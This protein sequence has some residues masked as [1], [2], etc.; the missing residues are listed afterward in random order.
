[1]FPFRIF[2]AFGKTENGKALDM[3]AK[4]REYLV[5]VW[6]LLASVV[7][8]SSCDV[9]F[10]RDYGTYTER[11]CGPT[12]TDIWDDGFFHYEQRFIFYTGGRGVEYYFD[13]MEYRYDFYWY[14]DNNGR[15]IIME[16]GPRDVS[17]FDDV[18]IG[19][20]I[21]SGYLDG[22]YVEFVGY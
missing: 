19:R 13:G 6:V 14:W 3:K 12:W 16:Y 18:V 11:L 21:L 1:M 7:G 22:Q 20:G 17:Y 10:Y 2:E 4:V 15:S 8:F 9:D 5:A